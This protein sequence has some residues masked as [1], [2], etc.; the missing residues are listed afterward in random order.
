MYLDG[1]LLYRVGFEICNLA[2]LVFANEMKYT[3]YEFD[4][5][6]R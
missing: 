4:P 3:R 1:Y 2:N 5:F 6:T